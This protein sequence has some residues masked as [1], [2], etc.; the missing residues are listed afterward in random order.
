[1]TEHE[2]R[3]HR[4]RRARQ[5]DRIELAGVIGLLVFV[6]ALQLSIAVAGIVLAFSIG[7]WALFATLHH[8]SVGVPRFFWPLLV[9]AA[10]TLVS[11]AASY[12]SAASFVDSK[13][14]V[15]FLIVP[16][17][18]QFGRGARAMTV[19]QVIITVGAASAAW[20]I[21]QYGLFNY[22]NLG[23]RPQGALGHYMTYSGLLMLVIGAAVARL[24]FEPRNRA[25]PAM[26]LPALLVAL[27]LTFTRSAWVGA[28]AVA[29]L[30]LAM[31]DFR[32][33]PVIPIVAAA[34][35]AI[36]P[37]Q[38]TA[39]FYSMFDLKDPTSRDR[40][41]MLHEGVAMIRAHPLTGVGPNMVQRL[42]AQYRDPTAVEKVNPHLHNVPM[43]IA[44]ER[45]LPALAAW[46]CF[47][48]IADDGPRTPA[49]TQPLPVAA[50]HRAR[51]DRGH[52]RGRAVRVQLRRLRVPD[53]VPRARHAAVRRRTS[54]PAV[55]VAPTLPPLP[56]RPRPRSSSSASR[57]RRCSSSATSCS[58]SSWSAASTA[59]RRK[60]RCPIVAF[61]HEESRVGGAANVAHNVAALGGTVHL[62]GLVGADAA[63]GHAARG[64]RRRT[65]SRPDGLVTDPDRRTTTKMRVVTDTQSAGGARRLRDRRRGRTAAIE[66]DARRACNGAGG[67]R[68]GHRR[69]RLPEGRVT[70]AADDAPRRARPERGVPLLVDPK[71]PHLDYYAG[72]TLVTPNH[73]EAEIAT[74]LRIR[75]R[76]RR[77][78]GRAGVPRRAGAA[79]VLI[80]RG[81]H[82]MWLLDD[83]SRGPCRPRRAKSPTSPARATP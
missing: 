41:A 72:A 70:R 67:N 63:G 8:E 83:S 14:L 25:W 47:V 6:G 26:I 4:G 32:L 27:V 59:S 45:G 7:C 11:A 43:Q 18:Y 60:R 76:G 82:G 40:V 1:M 5:R 50:G 73:H 16:M 77:A 78:G 23:Q 34:F 9:Y 57:A 69:V 3:L 55:T 42:Y 20:G 36:S 21:V 62:V 30:L 79:G 19:L 29:A 65:A 28:C 44:A 38:I 46:L 24:L 48:G 56:S 75:G 66:A 31:K 61:D 81:E 49:A 68:A 17:V 74:H 22:D 71:I 80:T 10:L 58:T 64:A 39:R 35:F 54:G 2:H 13:Q 12:D 52:A 53:A 15:L 51:R 37:P 33:L